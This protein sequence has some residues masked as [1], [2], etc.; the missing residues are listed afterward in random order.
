MSTTLQGGA[1]GARA[2][3]SPQEPMRTEALSWGDCEG[4]VTNVTVNFRA[5]EY[6]DNIF[7]VQKLRCFLI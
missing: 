1:T 5:V 3:V 2:R 6:N 7:F 4:T